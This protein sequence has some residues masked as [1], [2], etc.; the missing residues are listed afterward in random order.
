VLEQETN[1]YAVLPETQW[2][3][4]RPP[5]EPPGPAPG[6]W[7]GPVPSLPSAVAMA[8]LEADLRGKVQALATDPGDALA[9]A[10]PRAGVHGAR[11]VNFT[12]MHLGAEKPTPALKH[13]ETVGRDR[14]PDERKRLMNK[15]RPD[16]AV[17]CGAPTLASNLGMAVRSASSPDDLPPPGTWYRRGQGTRPDR[18]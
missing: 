17:L 2:R 15:R 11:L 7:G 13:T 12:G 18:I 1:V 9:R 10:L 16:E 3:G 14:P 8:A 5:A 6:T 4:Y